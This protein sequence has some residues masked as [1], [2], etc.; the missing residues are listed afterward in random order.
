MDRFIGDVYLG[1]PYWSARK[2]VV[3][4]AFFGGLRKTELESLELEKIVSTSLG[5]E[6]THA[7]AKQRSDCRE[8]KFL[9][10]QGEGEGIDYAEIVEEYIFTVRNVL[11]KSKGRCWFTGRHD[12]LVNTPMGK[13]ILGKI[14][15]EM[16]QR[17]QLEDPSKYTFHSYRR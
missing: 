1:T 7:R 9:I 10:P 11:G 3:L 16:A 15:M 4:T 14:P 17:L 8:T 6:I 12:I 13:N 5:V 2:A